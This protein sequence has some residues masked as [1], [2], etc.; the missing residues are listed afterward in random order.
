MP[1][2]IPGGAG[3][4][5]AE[6]FE[7]GNMSIAADGTVYIPLTGGTTL[8]D[9]E[10]C[11]STPD[12]NNPGYT[13][14]VTF[15][16][17][18][19]GSYTDTRT[20]YLMAVKPDGSYT[21]QTVDTQSLTG[22]GW[23]A[24]PQYSVFL[25][26]GAPDGQGGI[27]LPIEQTLYH[28]GGSN[29]SLPFQ[30]A[31]G[32]EVI[33]Q[34]DDLVLGSDGTAY[35]RQ[36]DPSGSGLRNIVSAVNGGAI[37]W[38]YQAPDGNLHL[39]SV[40]LGGGVAVSN[41]QLG[42]F[43]LEPTGNATSTGF[44]GSGISLS[45]SWNDGWYAD[46]LPGS[47]GGVSLLTLP[48]SVDPDSFWSGPE[49]D[50]GSSETAT[51]MCPCD[52]Q[53]ADSDPPNIPINSLQSP[54]NG[55]PSCTTLPGNGSTDLILVGDPGLTPHNVRSLF[56]LAAQQKANDLNAAGDN[57]IA[58]RISSANDMGFALIGELPGEGLVGQITGQV[59]Y[60][61]HSG[62]Y[63]DPASPPASIESILAAGEEG[64]SPTNP[65]PNV[66][67]Q[68]VYLMLKGVRTAYRG[69]NILSDSTSLWIF[70]CAPAEVVFDYFANNWISI[71]QLI[72][73]V[74]Q[75]GVYAYDVG[76]YFSHK[77][78]NHEDVKFRTGILDSNLPVYMVP[79]GGPPKKPMTGLRPQ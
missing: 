38:T 21:T 43:L 34:S 39:A 15:V 59:F 64:A 20:L 29:V 5:N 18:S 14:I 13:H 31:P 8:F 27:Y 60:F 76:V 32:N 72:S 71:A 4:T 26:R 10:P 35:V 45:S 56:N 75:H 67:A 22:P 78:A 24:S 77:D 70:G 79:V 12:P 9:G 25:Q 28:T 17:G 1:W 62:T 54:E 66:D 50:P 3:P 65:H 2:A 7:H 16:D 48:A 41:D 19:Q 37:N 57:V 69:K 74:I 53:T 52:A 11:D 6:S 68:D 47:G 33:P 30:V 63:H 49:G 61:G 51:P 40:L 46:N 23:Y 73:N 42:P 55:G 58:C 44:P 36:W